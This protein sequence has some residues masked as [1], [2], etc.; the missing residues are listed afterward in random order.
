MERG[1]K[2]YLLQLLHWFIII[3]FAVEIIYANYMIFSV[4]SPAEGGPLFDRAATF[5]IEMMVTRRLYAVEAWL[6]IVGLSIYLAITEIR[7]RM[8]RQPDV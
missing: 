5:P 6:A 1:V 8:H 3:N 2:F 4:F 7:P